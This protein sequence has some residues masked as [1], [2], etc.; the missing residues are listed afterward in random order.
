MKVL[1]VAALVLAVGCAPTVKSQADT[2][3]G[4]KQYLQA[5]ELYDQVLRKDPKDK[6]ALGRRIEA[7]TMV[8]RELLAATARARTAG[9][10]DGAMAQLAEMLVRRDGWG[11]KVEGELERALSIEVV[12][13]GSAIATAVANTS[14][15][16]GPL[17]GQA[18][19]QHYAPLLAHK[20]F[21]NWRRE[22]EDS[23]TVAARTSCVNLTAK[24]KTPYLTWA[25]AAYCR[26]F[27][28]EEPPLLARSNLKNR[29]V[30]DGGLAGISPDETGRIKDALAAAFA[31]SVWFAR[32]AARPAHAML[33][34]RINVAFDSKTVSR[35][36]NWTEQVP[37]T[38]YVQEQ[39][40]YQ[41]PYDDTETYYEQVP[42]TEY[43]S[44]S[45]PCGSSTC[46]E[47]RPE[48]VYRSESR[49]RTVTKYRTAFR[50]VTRPV[51]RYRAVPRSFHYEAIERSGRY[52]SNLRV[53]LDRDE[54]DVTAEIAGNFF[55][56][57][58]DHD[59]YNAQAGVSPER[60]NLPTLAAFAAAEEQRLREALR[61]KL[62]ARW[63]DLYCSSQAFTPEQ[64]ATCAYLAP[65]T[66]PSGAHAALQQVFGPDEALLQTVLVR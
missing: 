51:T 61:I 54:P 55:E 43:R 59:V 44:V 11:M 33:T 56:H 37:Y 57:G 25:I 27:G 66:I 49:T 20:E 8:L 5:A 24:A 23:V 6:H 36:A 30:I 28:L 62:D 65:A 31:E 17:S 7:R 26:H 40:S 52:A 21:A 12:A 53:H 47:S 64:A 13:S 48:T 14:N 38:D 58:F 3:F 16:A 4:K 2:A 63:A 19:A 1:Q 60:A 18:M 41:E 22:I 42:H 29:L 35:T 39:E 10:A 34:G 45:V 15:A 9:D 46:S 50:P 32:D